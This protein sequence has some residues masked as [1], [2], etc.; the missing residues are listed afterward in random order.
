MI[1][2]GPSL[3]QA[4]AQTILDA[5]YRPPLQA[6]DLDRLPDFAEVGIIDGMLE[7][8]VRLPL[9]EAKR[10]MERGI[11][12]FGAASTGALLA[13][14]LEPLGMIGVGR[15]YSFLCTLAEEK[16]DLIVVRQ[17]TDTFTARTVPLVNVVLGL[18]EGGRIKPIEVATLIESLREIPLE[19]RS[20]EVISNR[21]ACTH[22]AAAKRW[23]QE[24]W[25]DSKAADASFLLHL[26]RR[27][28]GVHNR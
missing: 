22:G 3:P 21:L 15:V 10:S 16:E 4:A 2:I 26:L 20:W 27:N 12:L 1:F 6:G 14:E 25:P 17:T 24:E 9:V 28:T 7:P 23:L 11:Q 5:D 18:L 13:T 8:A 19:D